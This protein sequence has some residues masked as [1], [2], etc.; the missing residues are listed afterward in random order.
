MAVLA[1][2]NDKVGIQ[3]AA[4]FRSEQKECVTSAQ[5]LDSSSP[6]LLK[7]GKVLFHGI[8][9]RRHDHES[10]LGKRAT[11]VFPCF[12]LLDATKQAAFGQALGY[13]RTLASPPPFLVTCDIGYCFDLYAALRQPLSADLLDRVREALLCVPQPEAAPF[14]SYL[15]LLTQLEQSAPDEPRRQLIAELNTLRGCFD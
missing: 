12:R 15:E 8:W 4:V 1:A 13:A 11:C 7:P 5:N 14:R 10:A 6:D 9:F 2:H 3:C